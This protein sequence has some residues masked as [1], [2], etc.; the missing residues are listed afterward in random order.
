MIQKT[1]YEI[2]DMF[3]KDNEFYILVS[4]DTELQE[5]VNLKDYVLWSK[6]LYFENMAIEI[7]KYKFQYIG[8]ANE[9]IKIKN[10]K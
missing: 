1:I 6:P 5:L 3:E 10:Y 4:V 7:D 2:G 9:L 8:K